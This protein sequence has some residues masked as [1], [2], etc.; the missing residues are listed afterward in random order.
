MYNAT[1]TEVLCFSIAWVSCF[2]RIR[3]PPSLLDRLSFIQPC[4]APYIP[5]P[6]SGF[7]FEPG[8]GQCIGFY[9][10]CP[11]LLRAFAHFGCF[12]RG[13]LCASRVCYSEQLAVLLCH[14]SFTFHS[15]FIPGSEERLWAAGAAR[16]CHINAVQNLLCDCLYPDDVS[17]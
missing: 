5:L 16:P 1:L 3:G 11:T 8:F 12:W 15:R 2:D 13:G 4:C 9:S 7:L 17:T 10:K 14:A 6:A